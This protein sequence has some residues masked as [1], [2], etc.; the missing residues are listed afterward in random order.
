VLQLYSYNNEMNKHDRN[1]RR[2]EHPIET[3]VL[4]GTR[5][6]GTIAHHEALL[7]F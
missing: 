6:A 1:N 7:R 5:N 3:L 2:R 4:Q